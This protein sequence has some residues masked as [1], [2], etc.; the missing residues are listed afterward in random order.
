MELYAQFGRFPIRPR[1]NHRLERPGLERSVEVDDS[2]KLVLGVFE[3][4][5][6][7]LDP[8]LSRRRDPDSAHPHQTLE[9]GLVDLNIPDIVVCNL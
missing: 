4:I 1:E 7:K 6:L 3:V 8:I 9:E 2:F 5:D